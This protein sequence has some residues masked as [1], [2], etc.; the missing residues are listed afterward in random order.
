M[1]TEA[2]RRE[3][4]AAL[5]RSLGTAPAAT[6]MDLLPPVGWADVATR[7][8]V[9]AQG[10]ALRGEMAE[11][12]GEMAEL[13]GEMAELRAEL[14]GEMAELRV[15]LKADIADVRGDLAELRARVDGLVARQLVANV[16][17]MFGVAGFVLAAAKLA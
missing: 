2:D 6:L 17:L 1:P 5:E 13:R 16:P 11:L 14:K 3:L 9:H 12:R 15:E 4:F 7:D 8:D 10:A